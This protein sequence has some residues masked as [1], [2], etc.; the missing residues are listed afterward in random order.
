MIK[1]P[2]ALAEEWG[3]S[4][5]IQTRFR[6][7]S[8]FHVCRE[9][10]YDFLTLCSAWLSLGKMQAVVVTVSLLCGQ[11]LAA[12][13]TPQPWCGRRLT[14]GGTAGSSLPTGRK[15]EPR[16]KGR[17][18]AGEVCIVQHSGP[19]DAV[20]SWEGSVVAAVSPKPMCS[21]LALPVICPCLMKAGVGSPLLC[22]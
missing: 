9:I 22:V 11:H 16:G 4:V 6:F 17:H 14:R 13:P 1:E 10:P 7:L 19:G 18:P 2:S 8:P 15:E 12:G 21:I 3:P 5:S 20:C